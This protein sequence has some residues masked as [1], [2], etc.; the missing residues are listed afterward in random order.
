MKFGDSRRTTWRRAVLALLAFLVLGGFM[1]VIIILANPPR[2]MEAE[3]QASLPEGFKPDP[4]I[5][6][7]LFYI[8]GCSNCH[9]ANSQDGQLA[10]RLVGGPPLETI[11]GTFYPPNITPDVSTGIGAW[12]GTDFVNA[13]VNGINPVGQHLYPSFPY[14]SYA[15][16]SYADLLHLKFYLDS[17]PAES[18]ES[19]LHDLVF[20]FNFRLGIGVWKW[21]FHDAS[22]W[23]PDP[24]EST[25]WNRG[26]YLV[27]GL[28]HC[29]SCHT[30]RNIFFAETPRRAFLGAPP[31][32]R[33]EGSAPKIAGLSVNKILNGLDEWSGS[34]DE[35]SSMFQ[36][37]QAF[38]SHVSYEDIDAVATYLS[39][40]P[41]GDSESRVGMGGSG[42]D[43]TY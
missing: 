35:K 11:F 2:I 6:E 42:G 14:T 13:M 28:G 32:K 1:L 41:E 24:D 43:S 16:V 37:T 9:A 22:P 5:G 10:G 30:P 17:L 34:I 18:K 40:L 33:E 4:T 20:P 12:S 36:V 27:N 23:A 3:L 39:S 7:S 25:D 8:G 29:G 31:L 38:S 26:N 21:A 15:K 19:Q